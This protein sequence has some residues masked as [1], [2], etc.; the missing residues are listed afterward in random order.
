MLHQVVLVCSGLALGGFL[1]VPVVE[2]S[3]PKSGDCPC[4]KVVEYSDSGNMTGLQLAVW[5]T[6]KSGACENNDATPAVCN[7]IT[8]H[9]CEA[10]RL[11]TFTTPTGLG[12]SKTSGQPGYNGDNGWIGIGP[13]S[14]G[15]GNRVEL[16][17]VC[18]QSQENEIR[19]FTSSGDCSGWVSWGAWVK[20]KVTCG[21]CGET[22]PPG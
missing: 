17:V 20:L 2:A 14:C 21:G 4:Y 18:G 22:Q 9:H 19:F 16:I 6:D 11:V 13:T 7:Q 8:I 3:M 1:A 10:S 12:W 15:S 5:G